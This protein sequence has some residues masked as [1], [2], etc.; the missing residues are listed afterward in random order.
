MH[1]PTKYGLLAAAVLFWAPAPSMAQTVAQCTA[2]GGGMEECL[3]ASVLRSGSQE[4]LA[5]F[6]RRH[7][8]ADTLWNAMAWTAGTG[9]ATAAAAGRAT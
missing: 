9:A 4:A 5:Q 8:N 6:Q 3:C 7:P 2:E 1:R